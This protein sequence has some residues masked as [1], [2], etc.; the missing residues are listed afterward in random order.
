MGESPPRGVARGARLG[1]LPVNFAGRAAA[2]WVRRVSG[3]DRSEIAAEV[4]LRNADQ[5]FA[6]LAELKGGAMKLG[7]LLAVYEAVIPADLAR[8]YHEALIKL[9]ASAPPM[10]A[11]VVHRV[12]GEQLGRRWSDRFA[13]FDADQAHAASIGQVHRA[14]WHDG[15]E[16]AVKV[17]YPGAEEAL[18]S[19][20]RTLRRLARLLQLVVPGADVRALLDEITAGMADELDYTAEAD[21]Q[22]RFAATFADDPSVAVPKVVA[23]SPKVIISEWLEGRP[24]SI[25]IRSP[26]ETDADQALRNRIGEVA[27][28]FLFSSPARV[29]LMHCDPHHGNFRLLEDGRLGVL[30]FG[31]VLAMPEGIPRPLGE[32]F[33]L[34]SNGEDEKFL[35]LTREQGFIGRAD[36]VDAR[37]AMAFLGAF[38]RVVA[39][40][41]FHFTREFMQTEIARMTNVHGDFQTARALDLPPQ[42]V[43]LV[44]AVSGWLGILAQLDCTFEAR[45]I[46]TRWVPGFALR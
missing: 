27:F 22:R 14:V 37:D 11:A 15:R 1:A 7:Q 17:Q 36:R 19:D 23:S 4:A 32:M 42:Y 43:M 46:L 3:A 9:Q 30:D 24:L 40:E 33:R 18:L 44:R 39:E 38:T 41:R 16:V 28:E 26:G 31:A 25:Y 12:L 29:G 10:P 21:N 13:E 2:G 8:P 5:L 34:A 35:Q 45:G 20:L 6:V